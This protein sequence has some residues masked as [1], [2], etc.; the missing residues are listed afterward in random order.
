[1][2]TSDPTVPNYRFGPFE[3]DPVE[4]HLSRDGTRVKLQDLPFRL[5]LMLVELPGEIVTRE[6]VRRRLWPENTF[7]EFDNS[8]GVAVRKVRDALGDDAESPRFV[9]TIP[10][11]GYR[12]LLPVKHASRLT[13]QSKIPDALQPERGPAPGARSSTSRLV[14]VPA[15]LL[16]SVLLVLAGAL[17]L[18]TARRHYAS[19]TEARTSPSRPEIRR[20]VAVL[21]FRNLPGR[22]DEDWMS[23][24]FTEMLSTELAAGGVLRL[25]SDE[26]VARVKRELVLG[27]EETLAKATLDRLRMNPGADVVVLGSYTPMPGKAGER[28]RLDV[29]LQDTAN[30]ETIAEE[31][32]TGSKEDLFEIATR[33]GAHLRSSLGMGAL[34]LDTA[35]GVRA[36]LPSNQAAI[37][38]YSEGKA[39]LWDFDFVGARDLLL[40]AVAADPNSSLAHSALSDTWWHLGYREK[41]KAEAMR[42]LELSGTLLQ[43]DRLLIEGSYRGTMEDWP[44][45]VEAYQTLFQ[46]HPDS[47][48][49][50]LLLAGAQHHVKPADALLMLKTL[51]Q[52]P[53]PAG[54]DPRIDL[55]EASSL[56][57]QDISAAQAAA[58]RAIAKGM[59]RGSHLMVARGYG[60]L[61]QQGIATGVS[62]EENISNCERAIQSYASAGDRNNEAR[63]RNDF[64]GVYYQRGDLAKAETMWREAAKEF[65]QVGDPGAFAAATNNIGDVLLLR[66]NLSHAK[67]MLELAI[68]SYQEIGDKDGVALVLNDLGDLSRRQGNL[69][70]AETTYQQAKSTAV[71]IDDKSAG[72][73]VLSGLGD[74]LKDRG[75]L[76]AARK[77]YEESLSVRTQT[78]QKQAAA[79]SQVALALV[80]IEEG[81][82]AD[83]ETTARKCRDQFHKEQEADDELA[84]TVVLIQTLLTRGEY[85]EAKAELERAEPL[86]NKS[87]NLLARLQFAL[88]SACVLLASD[89]P[90]SSRPRSEQV[91]KDARRHGYLGVEFEARLALAEL[92]NKSGHG[93]AAQ[94][95]LTSLERAANAKG[96]GLIARKAAAARK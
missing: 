26:D 8:L 77:S 20:S 83:A 50:G 78:G 10:K 65:R 62:T 19:T 96:F 40:K 25:V 9:E 86:A 85:S 91:L 73:F 69:T 71:E 79:E 57:T 47:L 52:L 33:A 56:N 23:K 6:E 28:I 63:T 31:A 89:H 76:S 70:S 80:S 75:E 1:M 66:G 67:K 43:E 94:A 46:L 7:V 5:L 41:A 72:A 81:H 55:L 95:Q 42:A 22:K 21:G 15:I 64:A 30:G 74:I 84:A 24:A 11:R 90:D 53:A 58:M 37:R 17:T 16:A 14:T 18:R 49:Y 36:S 2:P 88:T 38:F 44:K 12:F 45:A 61:C 34:S 4:G 59:S 3:L 13:E 82:P 93:A 92:D 32:V 29:R 51:R 48:G 35:N 39:K 27:D 60:I 87:Q 68:P 54:D